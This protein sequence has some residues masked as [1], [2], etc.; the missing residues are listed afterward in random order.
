MSSRYDT[1]LGIRRCS[2]YGVSG[3]GM[4]SSR[5]GNA[6]TLVFVARPTQAEAGVQESQ[7]TS[8]Q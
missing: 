1:L 7:Q 2:L 4:A 6:V 5:L 8:A 3:I